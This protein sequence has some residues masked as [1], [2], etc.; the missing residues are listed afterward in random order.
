MTRK[1][2][3]VETVTASSMMNAMPCSALAVKTAGLS[4][5]CSQMSVARAIKATPAAAR[6]AALSQR[7]GPARSPS[8]TVTIARD[9]KAAA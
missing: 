3:E 1:E 4:L 7:T 8:L 2:N 5:G 6:I 9:P